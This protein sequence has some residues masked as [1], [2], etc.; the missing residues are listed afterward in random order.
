MPK[1][2][3]D[4]DVHVNH[5]ERQR[6]DGEQQQARRALF[7]GLPVGMHQRPEMP[8]HRCLDQAH[9]RAPRLCTLASLAMRGRPLPLS[10][11]NC[12]GQ[13]IYSDDGL[14]PPSGDGTSAPA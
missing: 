13:F 10:L 1:L 8:P 12:P 11:I 4:L 3:A 7:V 2:A 6:N 5:A 9:T 14:S